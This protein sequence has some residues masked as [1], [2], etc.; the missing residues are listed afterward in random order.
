ME[1]NHKWQ[2][3]CRG[4]HCLLCGKVLTPDEY[5]ALCSEKTADKEEA[6]KQKK[7]PAQ[8]RAQAAKDEG[9]DDE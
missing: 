4:V 8:S 2:G 7:K 6:P 9:D 3:D 1:C 5:V